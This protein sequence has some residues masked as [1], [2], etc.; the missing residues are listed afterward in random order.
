MEELF[1]L[2]EN[3]DDGWGWQDP[4]RIRFVIVN[5]GE[6]S[7]GFLYSP[8]G[9]NGCVTTLEQIVWDWAGL[10]QCVYRVEKKEGGKCNG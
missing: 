8:C 10:G 9:C 2:L 4:V 3:F 1:E 7:K 6:V 5:G